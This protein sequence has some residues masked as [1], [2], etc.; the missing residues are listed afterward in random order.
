VEDRAAEQHDVAASGQH[1][2]GFGT[3]WRGANALGLQRGNQRL[4]ERRAAVELDK[5][6]RV[7]IGPNLDAAVRLGLDGSD[8]E[9][10]QLRTAVRWP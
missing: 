3:V 8:G 6:R 1:R 2:F 7:C 4:R 5:E 9:L 10:G